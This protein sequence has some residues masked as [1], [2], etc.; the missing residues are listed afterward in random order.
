MARAELATTA[1]ADLMARL[2]GLGLD[3]SSL[4]VVVTPRVPRRATRN[5][6]T[7]DARRRRE[8]TPGFDRPGTRL[9][10]V[11]RMSLTPAAL[12]LALGERISGRVVD[13]TCGAGGNAIGFARAGCEV[14]AIDIDAARLR[15]AR[16]NA[17]VYGVAHKIR[18]IHGDARQLD[19]EGD[20][21][22]FDPPWG[23]DWNRTATDPD[24]IPLLNDL[25]GRLARTCAKVPPS[26]DTRELGAE[27]EPWFGLEEGDYRRIKFL[28]LTWSAPTA[29]QGD[30]PEQ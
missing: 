14:T 24:S 10:E 22:F 3:G 8:T 15:L 20:L 12:A 6:R 11:G 5:A 29:T 23:A 18:F 4:E 9:D 21:L 28:T 7:I 19:L 25:R 13:A 1:A 27:V 26:T 2:R 30:Q 17:A 16:H